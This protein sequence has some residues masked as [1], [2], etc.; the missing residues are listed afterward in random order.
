MS[1]CGTFKN[2]QIKSSSCLA[3]PHRRVYSRN[4]TKALSSGVAL[5]EDIVHGLCLNPWFKKNYTR[6]S[7]SRQSRSPPL[8]MLMN[9]DLFGP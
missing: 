1:K 3:Q 5:T 8:A 4:K 6:V 2:R 7:L 9:K